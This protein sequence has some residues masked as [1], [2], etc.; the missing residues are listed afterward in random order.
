LRLLLDTHIILWSAA[1]PD[2]LTKN[3]KEELENDSNELWYSPISVWEIVL[4]AEKGRIS[5]GS[6]IVKAVRDIFHKIPLKEATT[7][8]EVAIQSRIVKLPHQDPADR[9]IAAT[10][11]VYDLTLVTA[12]ARIISAEAVAV[13]PAI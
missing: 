7:N 1:E 10:A 6:D 2:N 8:H 5:L 11:A 3:I 12:D 4:L 13:L 9:F